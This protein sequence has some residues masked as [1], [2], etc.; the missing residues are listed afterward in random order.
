MCVRTDN[1][2]RF[3]TYIDLCN[4]H[5]NQDSPKFYYVTKLP[6]PA[7]LDSHSPLLLI[8]TIVVLFRRS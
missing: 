2:M 8:V 7:L 5:R 4:H 3:N 1:P 6:H